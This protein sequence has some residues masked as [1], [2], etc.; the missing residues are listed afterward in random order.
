MNECCLSLCVLYIY[1][2]IYY[3]IDRKIQ[4]SGFIINLFQVYGD[5]LQMEKEYSR[6]F[7]Y[8]LDRRKPA[9]IIFKYTTVFLR[10]EENSINFFI[11]SIF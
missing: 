9:K 10:R 6:V 11:L 2:Y 4:F 3:R 1:I 5:P 8:N 7:E